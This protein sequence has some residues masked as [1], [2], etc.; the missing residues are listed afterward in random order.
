MRTSIPRTLGSAVL[1]TLALVAACESG[2]EPEADVS[3]VEAVA[4][5]ALMAPAGSSVL[6]PA[7]R[8]R[9]ALGA[10]VAGVAVRFAVASG[11]G[12]V[13]GSEARTDAQGVARAGSWKLGPQAGEQ[14]LRAEV[15]GGPAVVIRATAHAGPPAALRVVTGDGQSGMAGDRLP[16]EP[17]VRVEDANGNPVAGA[18][19]TF[20]AL[21]GGSVELG[22]SVSDDL[23]RA[24]AGG[25]TLGP[26]TG[27]QT[28]TAAAGPATTTLL[29]VVM[30]AGPAAL[31]AHSGDGQSATVG[32][33]VPVAPGV[34]V[35]DRFGNSVAGVAVRF[36]VEV[37]GGGI[38][39]SSPSGGS[40]VEVTQV[41]DGLGV[42]RVP[43]W[44]LGTEAGTNVLMASADGLPP[45]RITAT[46]RPGP[47]AAIQPASAVNQTAP[48]GGV[49]AESPAVAIRDAYGNP[50]AGVAVQF[51]VSG[52][53]GQI[54]GATA[55]TGVDG[56]ARA[57]SW[58]LGTSTGPQTARA[59]ASGLPPVTFTVTAVSATPASV[60]IAGG[61]QQ[62]AAVNA[63]LPVAP[64]VV[65]RDAVGHGVPGVSVT[66][67][68][69][70][71]GGSV[72]G[73]VATTDMDG[74]A[75]VG[76]WRLGASAGANVLSAR[77]G[78]LPPVSIG[79]TAVDPS[80]SGGGDGSYDVQLRYSTTVTD[81]QRQAFETA[82]ARWSSLVVGD[83]PDVNLS[84]P[85]G[86]CGSSQPGFAQTVDDLVIFVEVRTIDG[87]GKI[88]G[89]AGPCYIR[90]Q[91]GLPVAGLISLD[92]ADLASMEQKGTLDEVVMHEMGH[93]IGVGTLWGSKLTGAGGGNPY[94]GHAG[95]VAAFLNAGGSSYPGQP[96]PVENSGGAG[97]RDAHWRESVLQNELMT[98][99][100]STAGNPL[101]AITVASLGDL[102]Y[103][104]D[105]SGA[106][107]YA[108]PGGAASQAAGRG[109][110]IRI[111]EAPPPIRR[112]DGSGRIR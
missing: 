14:T 49:A 10:P 5:T 38:V 26:A 82:A 96:V 68:V 72:T 51:V 4:G 95:A 62:T 65:V 100:I 108:L 18:Q 94:F 101:S 75:R 46:G 78:S 91:G 71:G 93:V 24:A 69:V 81:R 40:L 39:G 83:L 11:G 9:D 16:L 70:S 56:I 27:T 59:T 17:V 22:A 67:T 89:S 88:L 63:I 52:G 37:G 92:A 77:A 42:A 111:E 74:I 85:S 110:M 13:E 58:T 28:L 32:T 66:F 84:V 31:E 25:W 21:A 80:G 30:P 109:E 34:V 106:D 23:G 90:M 45:V 36:A 97:T 50:I 8:V 15:R 33:A 3:T 99:Y 41:S 112:V 19:V 1:S 20:A 76:S 61:N 73:A 55:E 12:T 54:S 7:V 60:A 57:G 103:S 102:G 98:G 64:S 6:A 44:T 47:A 79:A 35:R 2:V 107:G 53:N 29:A 48:A 105:L 87:P 104:V 86:V 43:A